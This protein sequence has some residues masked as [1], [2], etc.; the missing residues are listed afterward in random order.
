M[1]AYKVLKPEYED[2]KYLWLRDYSNCSCHL[3]PPCSSCVH[4]G[5]PVN[6]EETPE[7]WE[8]VY[9]IGEC[10]TVISENHVRYLVYAVMFTANSAVHETFASW[11]VRKALNLECVI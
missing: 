1:K 6:L 8:L 5:N 2:L 3:C 9:N 10:G 7:A 11:S 4:E